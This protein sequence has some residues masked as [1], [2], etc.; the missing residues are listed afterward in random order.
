[1]A[2]VKMDKIY[3]YGLNKHRKSVLEHIH[4]SETLEITKISDEAELKNVQTEKTISQLSQYIASAQKSLKIL[5]LISP[6]KSGMFSKREKLNVDKYSMKSDEIERIGKLLYEIIRLEK[7][8]KE[9]EDTVKKINEEKQRISPFL[10][11]DIPMNFKGT[12]TTRTELGVLDGERTKEE[13][14]NALNQVG[15]EQYHFEIFST[16]KQQTHIWIIYSLDADEEIKKVLGEMGFAR[17]SFNLPKMTA[18]ERLEKLQAEENEIIKTNEKLKKTLEGYLAYRDEIK[19][20]YDHLVM[21]REKYEALS[22]LGLTENTFIISGYIPK[23]KSKE[24]SLELGNK[25]GVICEIED[26]KNAPVAFSNGGFSS[27][28]EGITADYAMPANDDIDPNPF[29]AVFYY[30]FFGMMF[31][32]AGYGLLMMIVC[33][34]LGYTNVLEKRKR[35][36]YRMFF[37]CGVST[38]F[39]GIMYAS[40]FGDLI[41]T[42]AKVFL[43]SSFRLK[44]LLF[45]PTQKPLELLI[46]SIAFGI[47]HILTALG[48]KFYI[49]WENGERTN[50]ICDTGV[51]IVTILG[52]SLFASGFLGLD[53]V[54]NIGIILVI[55][56]ILGLLLTGGRNSKSVVGKIF[57]GVLSLYDITS[58]VGDALSYS[59]LM[60]LGLATGV[61]A[62]VVNVIGSLGGASVLGVILFIVISIFGHALNFAINCLG[63]YIHTNRLQYVEF[64]QKFYKG[65]GRKFKPL[66]MNTK[67]Y[68]FSKDE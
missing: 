6:E 45:N 64:Y 22:L 59:R 44:P 7:T 37:F 3:I 50:A 67:Y 54:K 34:I 20:F 12:K 35:R 31:S 65:G 11:L 40:F 32:D 58:Y 5:D 25:F 55:F 23:K 1:M 14:I 27:P 18:K 21:R 38:T 10:S 63:A 39:W 17:A 36:A 4:K 33:G 13:I 24:F 47:V 68:D 41:D 62:S 51:W 52:I 9:N 29:M 46:L 30:L 49:T 66:S 53:T 61:I 16:S 2:I 57:G 19:L 15:L 60:A 56:G 42:V 48:I 28:V 26:A 43:N 8:I